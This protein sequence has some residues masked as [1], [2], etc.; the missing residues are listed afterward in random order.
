MT[1]KYLH[2]NIYFQKLQD[3]FIIKKKKVI[4]NKKIF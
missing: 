2:K 1:N 4:K 3:L